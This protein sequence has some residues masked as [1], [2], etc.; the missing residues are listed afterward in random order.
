MFGHVYDIPFEVVLLHDV[1]GDVVV[2]NVVT[3]Q[4]REHHVRGE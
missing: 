3:D 4:D 1:V 2:V